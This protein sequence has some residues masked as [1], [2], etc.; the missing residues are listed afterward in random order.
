MLIR[1]RESRHFAK[2]GIRRQVEAGP[3]TVLIGSKAVLESSGNTAKE[4]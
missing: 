4:A 2:H 1:G 3:V